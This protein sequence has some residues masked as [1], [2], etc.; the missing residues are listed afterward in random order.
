[1]DVY[2]AINKRYSVR[3]YADQPVEQ[4]KLR[5]VLDAGR[6]SPSARNR[7]ERKFI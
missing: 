2:E 7:Q 5:R 6:L 1:M 3:L 4:D